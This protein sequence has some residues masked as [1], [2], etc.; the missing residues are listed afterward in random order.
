MGAISAQAYLISSAL[1]H[2]KAQLLAS[3]ISPPYPI[4]IIAS[5]SFEDSCLQTKPCV[6]R[7]HFC[8][9]YCGLGSFGTKLTLLSL[10]RRDEPIH[11]DRRAREPNGTFGR[12]HIPGLILLYGFFVPLSEGIA[13][14]ESSTK[15]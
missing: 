9:L 12:V 13:C 10:A 1:I 11:I 4:A 7:R 2:D 15:C 6:E 3:P 5:D 14:R 8:F